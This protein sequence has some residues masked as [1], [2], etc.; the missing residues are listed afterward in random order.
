MNRTI[1]FGAFAVLATVSAAKA[2]PR[3]LGAIAKSLAGWLA[4]GPVAAPEPIPV[5]VK[6]RRHR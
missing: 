2:F 6:V 4:L 5:R 1:A 3:T